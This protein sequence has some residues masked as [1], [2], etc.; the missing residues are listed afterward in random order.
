[1]ATRTAHNKRSV[2]EI[3]AHEA[4]RTLFGDP[5]MTI[6]E[7]AASFMP[8]PEGAAQSR[9]TPEL[10]RMLTRLEEE[11]YQLPPHVA[12]RRVRRRTKAE[13]EMGAPAGGVLQVREYP[14]YGRVQAGD[15]NGSGQVQFGDQLDE[16]YYTTTDLAD[17]ER[18]PY[19]VEVRGH[20]MTGGDSVDF[21]EGA[22]ALVNPNV[23]PGHGDFVVVF[24][25]ADET[26]T[27]KQLHLTNGEEWLV[28]LNPA[29]APFRRD[30]DRHEFAGVVEEAM[31]PLYK[32]STGV[33]SARRHRH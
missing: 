1:M 27:F 3:L 21:P 4:V 2:A 28:P 19:A 12:A 24:D 23:A 17:G 18:A 22:R 9:F 6:S 10:S 7:A 5:C 33:K 30:P 29:Y 25:V 11:G 15:F 31:K 26:V 20:S 13:V 16:G 32:R 8:P 14:V